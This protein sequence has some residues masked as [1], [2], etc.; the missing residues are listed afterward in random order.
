MVT[1]SEEPREG[2]RAALCLPTG[3]KAPPFAIQLSQQTEAK[4]A[5]TSNFSREARRSWSIYVISQIFKWVN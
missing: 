3:V 5:R 4:V 1:S 2:Q